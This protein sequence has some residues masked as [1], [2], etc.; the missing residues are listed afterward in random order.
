MQIP[1]SEIFSSV[2]KIVLDSREDCRNGLFVPIKGEK[3]DGHRL[4]LIHI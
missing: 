4:S 1:F 3:Q 2:E